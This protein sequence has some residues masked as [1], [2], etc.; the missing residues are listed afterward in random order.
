[1]ALTDKNIVI[2]PN[3]GQSADPQI[4][5]SGADASTGPQNITVRVY[6]TSGGTLSVE[7]SAGQ[8]FSIT[9]SLT[10]TIYSV[11]DISGIP[12]IEVLDTG[13]V[14]IAQYSGNVVLGSATDNGVDK[15][16]VTGSARITGGLSVLQ[17]NIAASTGT[18]NI[19]LSLANNFYITLS[20]NTTFT[21]SN[22]SNKIGSSG[23]I[24]L[25]QD[26]T[27]GRTFTK[28]TEMK[29]PIGGAAI[30]QTTTAN[31]LS[32]LSYYVADSSNVLINYMGN[33]A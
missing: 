17:T 13:L 2:T 18:T 7:G 27:G 5:F 4:V 15:L 3:I 6:P 19:D 29:T 23:I 14:K 33:F 24:V 28:A 12:S 16:Q 32:M 10:G 8:L 26:A 21:L 31:S 11:N 22:I 30:S 25:K 1:M 20:A 9:N